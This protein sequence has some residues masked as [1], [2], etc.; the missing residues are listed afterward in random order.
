M[1]TFNLG[2]WISSWFKRP[3]HLKQYRIKAIEVVNRIKAAVESPEADLIVKI[4]PGY[5]DD[6]VL[7]KIRE[8]L[9]LIL[10][11]WNL[12]AAETATPALYQAV[13]SLRD[14]SAKGR[15]H[16]Y[17][18][19]AGDIYKQFSGLPLDKAMAQVEETYKEW[20]R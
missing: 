9:P 15:G 7:E 8:W 17:S 6:K 20:K 16:Y 5:T 18:T 11:H 13:R 19:V 12:A 10:K 1:K 4:I 2:A 14:L 3:D